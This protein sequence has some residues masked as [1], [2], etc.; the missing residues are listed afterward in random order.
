MVRA[1]SVKN[2]GTWMGKP[3]DIIVLDSEARHCRRVAM[4]AARGLEF[5]L[6][7]PQTVTLRGGDALVLEDGRLVEVLAQ[8][9][10]LVEI[11]CAEPRQVVRL[12]YHF[13]NRHLPVQIVGQKLRIRRDPV[14]E[15]LARKGGARV[16]EI[17]AP[18]DPES[19][20]Y[21]AEPHEHHDH[22]GHDHAHD[23]HGHAH[24]D[25]DHHGH[26]HH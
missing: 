5:L 3:A 18:F 1:V 12:A 20:A 8:P 16:T 10:E 21:A 19:G 13:G 2:N 9:E 22:A 7:L 15:D 26:D 4:K 23:D 11:A 25:H 6:D 17:E 14:I 24:D